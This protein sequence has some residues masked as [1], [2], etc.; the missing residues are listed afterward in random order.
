MSLIRLM[1]PLYRPAGV[2]YGLQISKLATTKG[3]AAIQPS[4]HIYPV[5]DQGWVQRPTRPEGE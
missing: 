1:K 5:L 4:G 2:I 3:D